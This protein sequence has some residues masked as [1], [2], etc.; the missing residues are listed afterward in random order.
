MVD[1][2]GKPI[3]DIIQAIYDEREIDADFLIP[4]HDDLLPLESLLDVDKA[5]RIMDE[6]VSQDKSILVFFDTDTDGIT[7]GVI[8]Y[9][10]LR[11]YGAKN[12]EWYINN[13]K[14]HGIQEC[15]I[16][17][18]K[19]F[20]LVI[21]VDSISP[22]DVYRKI[23]SGGTEIIVL[24]HHKIS[25]IK[26]YTDCITLVSSQRQYGNPE[27]SGAGV[28]W[29]FCKYID[30]QNL[31][32]YADELIDLAA[33]GIIADVMSMKSRENRYICSRG[34]EHLRN[35]A[36]KNIVGTF[37]F[38]STAVQFSIAPLINAA[39]RMNENAVAVNAMLETD[40]AVFKEYYK[41]LRKC[42]DTQTKLVDK[43]FPDLCEEAEDQLNHREKFIFGVLE[44]NADICGLLSTKLTA[45]YNVPSIVV[46]V[47]D[48][49]YSGSLR[50]NTT[51][52]FC[53]ICNECGADANGHEN[54]AG[55]MISKDNFAQFIMRLKKCLSDYP[56]K[57]IT[58]EP[59]IQ[60]SL[61]DVN[62]VLIELS[63]NINK[64]TGNNFPPLRFRISGICDYNIRNMSNGKH[65]VIETP[66][67]SFIQW[68]FVG[69]FQ[70]FEKA[71]K[72]RTPITFEGTLTNGYI[73]KKF[74]NQF[75]V[76]DF[77]AENI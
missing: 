39:N 2:R 11:K 54:A 46:T 15:D 45:R 59:D 5:Y 70:W 30:E 57:K 71:Q 64:L 55:I 29:K 43:I 68:N 4:T 65:L 19:R 32:D 26:N 40:D 62:P 60:I 72:N 44:D 75:I 69:D 36:L 1:C 63:K 61:S 17:Y 24:D 37:P 31:S 66:T 35:K 49:Y 23:V 77:Y 56:F 73:G 38:N 42:R 7:S 13:R 34:F 28:V 58:T 76:D 18:F 52:D 14:I 51:D 6:A 67:L 48:D 22:P 41:K 33:V 8:M 3:E 50:S 16:D 10:Y 21:V 9:Q 20:Q 74:L 12:V 25:D 47:Y 27:L 53:K